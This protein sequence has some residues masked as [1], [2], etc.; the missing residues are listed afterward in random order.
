VPSGAAGV[1]WPVHGMIALFV[2][3]PIVTAIVAMFL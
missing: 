2:G 1:V 3:C